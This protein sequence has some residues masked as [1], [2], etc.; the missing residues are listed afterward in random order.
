MLRAELAFAPTEAQRL[1][2]LTIAIGVL[3]GIA[4]VGF[5][6]LIAFVEKHGMLSS[7]SLNRA[8]RT[9]A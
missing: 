1:L 3:C 2:A 7:D 9:E 8:M 4:A 6:L 5:H